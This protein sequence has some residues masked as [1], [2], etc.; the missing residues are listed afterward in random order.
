[1]RRSLRGEVALASRTTQLEPLG[2]NSL[3]VPAAS[4]GGGGSV[5]DAVTVLEP[6]GYS[7]AAGP[8]AAGIA[9]RAVRSEAADGVWSVALLGDLVIDRDG[10]ITGDARDVPGAQWATHVLVPVD[11]QCAFVA[12]ADGELELAAA[13]DPTRGVG[14]LRFAGAPAELIPTPFADVRTLLLILVAAEAIGAAR[15]CLDTAVEHAKAREQFG[16]PIGQFQAVKHRCADMLVAIE[17]AAAAV[18]D[19]ARRGDADEQRALAAMIAAE[20]ATSA[21]VFAA[22]VCIQILGGIGVTWEHDAHLY[23][24]RALVD[25]DLVSRCGVDPRWIGR[26]V[27]EGRGC[28]PLV[29]VEQREQVTDKVGSLMSAVDDLEQTPTRAQ[30]VEFGLVVPTWVAPWGVDAT[31]EESAAIDA[32]LAERGVPRTD[33]RSARWLLPAIIEHGTDAQRERWVRPALERG[34][35]WCQMFSEP[36]AGSD[37]ASLSCRAEQTAE[38]WLVTGQKVWV[39]DADRARWGMCLV[40]TDRDRARHAGISCVV[41]DLQA[42][43]VDI[44]PIRDLVGAVHFFEIFLDDV[45]VPADHLIGAAEDGWIVARS[46]MQAEREF[47]GGDWSFGEGV[48]QLVPAMIASLPNADL[49][50]RFGRLAANEHGIRALGQRAAAMASIRKL[51]AAQH[52]QAI[53]ELGCVIAGDDFPQWATSLLDSQG[54]TIGGGTPEMQRNEISQQ[55]L[56]LPRDP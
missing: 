2:V 40:R 23:L 30:L 48:C 15:W 47:M 19:A 14:N 44:R 41:V 17:H 25:R 34:E 1:V 5:L 54:L 24:R 53:A 50:V 43:G 27:L 9:A 55:L 36:G 6:L 51:L 3:L 45:F 33:L 31:A 49:V 35:L 12:S 56:G 29:R 39:S 46:M 28:E 42:T 26:E 37:L 16:R 11:G 22:E 18:S 8:V 4:G 20:L 10:R 32:E 21:H 13:V 38:G 52:G 7:L